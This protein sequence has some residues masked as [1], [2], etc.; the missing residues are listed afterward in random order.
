MDVY[1]RGPEDDSE[2]VE[3]CR[4]KIAFLWNKSV[5]VL[6]DTLCFIRMWGYFVSLQKNVF[7]TELWTTVNN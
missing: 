7:L 1:F 5:V 2:R 4:P 6:T 3:T